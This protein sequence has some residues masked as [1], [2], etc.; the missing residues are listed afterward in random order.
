MTDHN[1]FTLE[2][3]HTKDLARDSRTVDAVITVTAAG[4][5]DGAADRTRAAEVVIVDC[6]LSM[7]R[8]RAKIFAA[9]KATRAAIDVLRDGVLFGIIAGREYATLVYPPD[10]GLVPASPATRAAA[11]E[12]V[13]GLTPDGGT[14]IGSWLTLADRLLTA[15]PDA[16]RHAMLF[17]DGRNEHETPQQLTEVLDRVRGHFG[18]DVRGVGDAWEPQELKR[19]VSVLNGQARGVAEFTGM[20]DDFSA[21][22]RE[23]MRKV[24]PDVDLRLRLFGGTRLRY[25]KQLFPSLLDVTDQVV[26]EDELVTRLPTGSWADGTRDYQV[27][28]AIDPD[29]KP[30]HRDVAVARIELDVR[31][32]AATDPAAPAMVL[33]NWTDE[34]SPR[35]RLPEEITRGIS[36]QRLTDAIDAG[37]AAAR[38]EDRAT[39]EER[40]GTAVRL[41]TELG[42]GEI[43]DALRRVVDVPGDPAGRVRLK[44]PVRIEDIKGLEVI[45]T[46]STHDGGGRGPGMAA[47]EPVTC[48]DCGWTNDPEP[49]VCEQC[50]HPFGAE[51]SS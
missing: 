31:G 40:F 14:A 11:R 21:L 36:Q 45:S 3:S 25:V 2:V 1:G 13:D 26:A 34:P 50:G 7:D 46:H 38:R 39:A 9:R 47:G 27:G 28:L 10:G 37:C 18:C 22:M 6:S 12:V 24:V 42:N 20:K 8:P 33:V 43:L 51:Q 4:L 15:H 29:G 5:G 44:S 48:P 41:A 32:P 23:A 35:T 17:T 49:T 30:L 16:V 19:I